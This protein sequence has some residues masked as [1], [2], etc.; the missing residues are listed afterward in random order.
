MLSLDKAV[1]GNKVRCTC[2]FPGV[3]IETMGLIVQDYGT[4]IM[5]AWDLS[6]RPLPDIPAAEIGEMYALNP[7]CP[8]RDGFDKETE[9]DFLEDAEA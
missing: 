9:L 7:K 6:D 5:V 3:P 8:L 2:D 1:V 4:G